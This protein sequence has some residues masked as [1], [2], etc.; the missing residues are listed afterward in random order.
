VSFQNEFAYTDDLPALAH[1][2]AVTN[3][4]PSG[5]G[6]SEGLLVVTAGENLAVLQVDLGSGWT[7]VRDDAIHPFL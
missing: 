2:L 4:C 1:C 3:F 5:G 6:V 7:F